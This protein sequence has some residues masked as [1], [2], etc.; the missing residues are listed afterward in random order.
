[1]IFKPVSVAYDIF[2]AIIE[3]TPAESL[4]FNPPPY[5]YEEI[6][7]PFDILS[8]D[9]KMRTSLLR[10]TPAENEKD[11]WNSEIEEFKLEFKEFAVYPE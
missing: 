4:K 10:R 3:T 9:E 6:L 8:G 2:D 11:R 5:E 1:M 7:M